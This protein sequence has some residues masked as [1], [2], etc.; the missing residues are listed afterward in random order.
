MSEPNGT[1]GSRPGGRG[2]A[3]R[4]VDAVV[5]PFVQPVVDAVDVEDVVDRIDVEALIERIDLDALLDRIDPD[6]LL[7]RVDPN[8]LLDRVD[9]NRLLDRVDPNAL[10]DRVDPNALL[11]RVD[12]NT[13][14]D[15]V[16][17]DR[18]LD[19]VDPNRLLER[20]DVDAVMARVDVDAVMARV[21][22]DAV[23]ARVDV[24]DLVARTE[25]GE[26]IARSTT[27]VFGQ[28]VDTGRIAVMSFDLLAHGLVGRVLRRPDRV[29]PA[30]PGLEPGP[31]DLWTM[32]RTDRAV[33]LQGRHAGVVS[34][35]L[36]FLVDS[37]L[38]G[39]L[40]GLLATLVVTALDVVTSLDWQPEDSPWLVG[41]LYVGW[42]FAY[43][44]GLTAATGRTIGKAVLGLFVVAA[45]GA[46]VGPRQAVVRTLAF[47]ISFLLFGFGFLLGLLRRDRR[48]LHDLIGGTA[49][50]YAWDA[51]LARLRSNTPAPDDPA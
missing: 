38:V 8:A 6:R 21:D 26:I 10:L 2:L 17:P 19:R 46:P 27:G 12:P 20:V 22:V 3:G 50:V 28:L 5:A 30:G 29:A 4:V 23:M 14:L 33:A 35:F 32:R 11:D 31:S 18:L 45:D 37:T 24:N 43:F 13:L 9:P 48:Q 39:A 1:S 16:D 51:E 40:F 15:R 25:L 49:V 44:A 41:V 42:Q 36:A 34:R 47:P 7:D